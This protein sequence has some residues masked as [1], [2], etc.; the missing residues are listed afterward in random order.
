[1]TT[2]TRNDDGSWRRDDERHDNILIDTS[3]VP[4]FLAA[5]GLDARVGSAFGSEQLP[6]GLHTI[7]GRRAERR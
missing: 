6:G 7:V 2:F 1:M 4:A 3:R 5:H